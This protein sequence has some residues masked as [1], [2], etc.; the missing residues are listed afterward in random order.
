MA[1]NN[2]PIPLPTA[3]IFPDNSCPTCGQEIKL[4]GDVIPFPKQPVG[5]G[6]MSPE[7]R[8]EY[9]EAIKNMKIN[10]L[11]LVPINQWPRK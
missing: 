6:A 8:Q 7:I 9:L 4:A 11:P 2:L 1:Y 3:P 5:I 10:P